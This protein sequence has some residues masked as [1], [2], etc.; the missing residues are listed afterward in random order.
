[1]L[2]KPF[3]M[4]QI[5]EIAQEGHPRKKIGDGSHN[6]RR[7]RPLTRT[8]GVRFIDDAQ[9]QSP[10]RL[11]NR[12][13]GGSERPRYIPVSVEYEARSLPPAVLFRLA[14]RSH[15]MTCESGVRG[16]LSKT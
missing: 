8:R 9:R 10:A 2:T 7:L 4:S 13:A 6:A 1:M 5:C 11:K 16:A 15:G 14:A 3:S 12:A